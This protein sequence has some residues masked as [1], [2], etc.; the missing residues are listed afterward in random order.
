MR[1]DGDDEIWTGV[2]DYWVSRVISPA[3][4][5][6]AR[7]DRSLWADMG[8]KISGF[9]SNALVGARAWAAAQRSAM[10]FQGTGS[11]GLPADTLTSVV[12]ALGP[13]VLQP[14]DD[15]DELFD[16]LTRTAVGIVVDALAAIPVVGAIARAIG[17]MG[18]MLWDLS[19]RPQEQARDYLPPPQ[20]YD[21]KDEEYVMNTQLLP[22]LSTRD[23]TGLFLPRVGNDLQLMEIDNGWLMRSRDGGR[24]LGFIPGTQ[25]IN[26][27]TQAFWHKKSSRPGGSLAT[28]QDVGDFYPG[29]AQ[30]MTA[31]DQHV[32]RPGPAMWSV[33]PSEVRSIWR[34]HVDAVKGFA[35]EAYFGRGIKG[36][37]LDRLNEEHRR[38]IV[39]QL[40][41]PLHVVELD[42]ELRRGIL[43]ANSWTPKNPPDDII[44]AFVDPWC[45]RLERRQEQYLETIAVAYADPKSAAF[46]SN[47]KLREKLQ[48]MRAL[49][50]EHPARHQVD[51]RDVID[52][53]YRAALFDA[54]VGDQLAAPTEPS[55]SAEKPPSLGGTDAEPEPPAPPQGGAPFH[56]VVAE[57]TPTGEGGGGLAVGLGVLGLLWGLHSVSRRRRGKR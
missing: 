37:G 8:Q 40:V 5:D 26:S 52:P 47:A 23:W 39:Q 35:Y 13:L 45:D 29:P 57:T 16:R 48:Q 3:L 32:Q 49:L 22:A 53:E 19:K 2:D 31:L 25:Q 24:G 54:T 56:V 12:D 6:A 1:L 51:Q 36:T 4:L 55:K 17:Q 30:L 33:V 46:V 34:D 10:L 9:D 21:R 38:L 44:E 18:L 14:P 43:A 28:H 50:L 41:A 11:L 15:L 27:I 42:G 7:G 20:V